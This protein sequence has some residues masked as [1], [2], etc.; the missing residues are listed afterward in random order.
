MIAH[1][2]PD[3]DAEQGDTP[4]A[5]EA[6]GEP[7]R[8]VEVDIDIEDVPPARSMDPTELRE[9]I[10]AGLKTTNAEV[11]ED[12]AGDFRGVHRDVM[13]YIRLQLSELVQPWLAWVLEC[14][15]NDRLRHGYEAGKIL[16]W[17]LPHPHDP[18]LLLIFESP[19]AKFR[20]PR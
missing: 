9:A 11:L 15:E 7:I 4:V 8:D 20:A 3:Q 10:A 6:A 14:C 2:D 13:E 17:T 18:R 19:R 16:V 5:G 1:H 12:A